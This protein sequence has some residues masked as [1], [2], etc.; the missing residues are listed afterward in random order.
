VLA[1]P[2]S[3]M[4]AEQQAQGFMSRW[5]LSQR[6]F[7]TPWKAPQLTHFLEIDVSGLDV[8]NPRPG[9]FLIPGEDPLDLTGR[10]VR[11]GGF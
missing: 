2:K 11:G 7:T 6:L 9:T 4:S 8:L 3:A 10:I 1:G 5:Q